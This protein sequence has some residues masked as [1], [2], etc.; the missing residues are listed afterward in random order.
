MKRFFSAL[1]CIA[2]AIAAT[3]PALAKSK[4]STQPAPA[5]VPAIVPAYQAVYGSIQTVDAA[6]KRVTIR[7]NDDKDVTLRIDS[8]T[9][10]I[11][12]AKRTTV[13]LQKIKAGT[14]AAAWFDPRNASS[15][16]AA[17]VLVVHIAD[18][19]TVPTYFEAERIDRSGNDLRLLNQPQDIVLTVKRTLKIKLFGSSNTQN[20]GAIKPGSQFLAWYD[21]AAL[22]YPAQ[23]GTDDILLFPYDYDGYILIDRGY[24]NVNGYT[25]SAKLIITEDGS[26]LFPILETA[27]RLGFRTT[28]SAGKKAVTIYSGNRE[29]IT[30]TVGQTTCDF[31]CTFVEAAAPRIEN[32]VFYVPLDPILML[33]NYKLLTY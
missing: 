1:L 29:I 6:N 15:S 23:A 18:G 19:A 25:L 4:A 32:N 16:P 11:D 20:A 5:A 3:A 22:S 31:G 30:F 28:Y 17:L 8:I 12:N 14:R 27:K 24:A 13:T 9:K 2:L 7:T 21:T 33:G 10:V 26:V